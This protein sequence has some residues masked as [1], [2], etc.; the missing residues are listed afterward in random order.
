MR[1][2][3]SYQ[4]KNPVAWPSDR[5]NKWPGSFAWRREG[6]IDVDGVPR[7]F[8]IGNEAPQLYCEQALPNRFWLRGTDQTWH[9][10]GVIIDSAD[11]LEGLDELLADAQRPVTLWFNWDT[12]AMAEEIRHTGSVATIVIE[13]AANIIDLSALM[14][15]PH[16]QALYLDCPKCADVSLITELREL[17]ALF[18]SVLNRGASLEPVRR[19]AG[20]RD[21]ALRCGAER[22]LHML[23]NLASLDSLELDFPSDEEFAVVAETCPRLRRLICANAFELRELAPVARLKSLRELDID[24]SPATDFNALEALTDLESLRLRNAGELRDLAALLRMPKLT[25]LDVSGCAK[26]AD[27]AALEHMSQLTSLSL[28]YTVTDDQLRSIAR[29]SANLEQLAVEIQR[30]QTDGRAI[31]T[32]TNLRE[33]S[34]WRPVRN[35]DALGSM[36][37]LEVAKIKLPDDFRD[38]SFLTSFSSLRELGLELDG[39]VMD[40]TAFRNLKELQRLRL[41]CARFDA[42]GLAAMGKLVSASLYISDEVVNVVALAELSNLMFLTISGLRG[43]GLWEVARNSKLLKLSVS[44]SEIDDLSGLSGALELRELDFDSCEYLHSLSGIAQL[45]KVR[46]LSFENCRLKGDLAVLSKAPSIKSLTLNNPCDWSVDANIAAVAKIRTLRD[47]SISLWVG[48]SGPFTNSAPL[49]EL[50]LLECLKLEGCEGFM[51]LGP[52]EKLASLKTLRL[53]RCDDLADLSPLERIPSLQELS[54]ISCGRVAGLSAIEKLSRLRSLSLDGCDA[55]K[56][57]SPL[58]QLKSLVSLDLGSTAVDDFSFLK[59]LNNLRYLSLSARDEIQDTAALAELRARG[60][61]VEI[62][63]PID[64]DKE[65]QE[66]IEELKGPSRGREK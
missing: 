10:A 38:L 54:L 51:D 16:L 47:L 63:E 18:L 3:M 64:L 27:F 24:S 13:P 33:L 32:L 29:A 19:A 56:D 57:F 11:D 4:P 34:V 9:L 40:P 28:P 21:L 17:R 62:N 15:F 50:R 6:W 30:D 61:A 36:V 66:G 65:L 53:D 39:D 55:I 60:C 2:T 22:D 1:A 35:A 46:K 12:F 44:N 20:L 42:R 58:G 5:L 49:G 7:F 25:H 37:K 48:S 52:L 59:K 41:S 43:G 8:W 45:P 14:R 23:A 26:L 31:S